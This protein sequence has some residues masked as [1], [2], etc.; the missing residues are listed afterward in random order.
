MFR[1]FAL[2]R[3][4]LDREGVKLNMLLQTALLTAMAGLA[5]SCASLAPEAACPRFREAAAADF[6]LIY[7]SDESIFVTKPDTREN[8]FLPLLSRKDIPGQLE[9]Y[10]PARHLAVVVIGKMS[11]P[12]QAALI[13]DWQTWLQARGFRRFVCLQA[14][15]NDQIAGLPILHDSAMAMNHVETG[16]QPTVV[17]TLTP[18]P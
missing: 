14:G 3:Q 4:P 15:Y 13:Q 7:N 1:R 6:V 18:A 11:R 17:A 9:Q 2:A 16:N 12:D 8:G 5:V 10:A